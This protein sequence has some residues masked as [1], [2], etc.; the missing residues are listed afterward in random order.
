MSQSNIKIQWFPPSWVGIRTE[1]SI[2]YIDPA[3][4]RT[5]FSHYPKRIEFTKWPDPI[6]GLPEELKKADIILV[7]HHHKDHCKHVTVKRLC[8][9]DTQVVAPSQC[10]KELGKGITVVKHGTEIVFDGIRVKAVSAYNLQTKSKIMHK[11]GN[12]VGYL[13]GIGDKIVYHAGDTDY[14][15]EMQTIG[16]VD[17]ALLPIGGRGFTMNIAEAVKATEILKPSIVI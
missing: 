5:N 10:V 15:P 7:T 6:D 16:K 4:L 3:Y 2:L 14:I 11:K 1:K 9:Q 13:I 8:K 17:V 12:G